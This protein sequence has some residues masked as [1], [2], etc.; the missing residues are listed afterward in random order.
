QSVEKDA[1][2]D[3]VLLSRLEKLEASPDLSK[4]LLL[5]KE[6]VASRE[7]RLV[8]MA[9]LLIGRFDHPRAQHFLKMLLSNGDAQLRLVALEAVQL[10]GT[11]WGLRMHMNA[12]AD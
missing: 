12:L 3:P 4:L 10:G 6:L 7:M 8:G 11:L 2:V 1:A 5:A 9:T